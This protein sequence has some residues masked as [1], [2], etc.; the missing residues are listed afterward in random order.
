MQQWNPPEYGYSLVKEQ[1]DDLR[2]Q[3]S[4]D[5]MSKSRSTSPE[6]ADGQQRHLS[7]RHLF[8]A[9]TRGHHLHLAPRGAGH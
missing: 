9:I 8:H 6:P 5:R 7:V 1:H 4:F 3:A 2:R